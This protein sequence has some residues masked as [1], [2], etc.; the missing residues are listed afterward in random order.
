MSKLFLCDDAE[1]ESKE[2]RIQKLESQSAE[3]T[4]ALEQ[5]EYRVQKLEA[6]VT[7]V[8]E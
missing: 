5:L 7:E 6:S 8:K 1:N 2:G 4:D 3:T